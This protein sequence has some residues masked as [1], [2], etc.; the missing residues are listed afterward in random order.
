VTNLAW[1]RWAGEQR[2]W[3]QVCAPVRRGVGVLVLLDFSGDHRTGME[4][5]GSQRK[6]DVG[7]GRPWGATVNV[8]VG[9]MPWF[10]EF[11]VGLLSIEEWKR[12]RTIFLVRRIRGKRKRITRQGITTNF[13]DNNG[14]GKRWFD[15]IRN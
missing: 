9:Y 12:I 11:N 2:R 6:P 1:P 13:L 5:I 8:N 4:K 14:I 7:K 3:W 10:Q 15:L